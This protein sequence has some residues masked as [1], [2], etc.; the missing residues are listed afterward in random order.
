[1]D[2]REILINDVCI[3]QDECYCENKQGDR[4]KEKYH[5]NGTISIVEINKYYC[6]KCKPKDESKN[7]KT[8]E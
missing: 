6:P 7:N 8:E 5:S 4:K 2:Y 1:M 3:I